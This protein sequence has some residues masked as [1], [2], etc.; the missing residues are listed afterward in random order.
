MLQNVFKMIGLWNV[1][2][3]NKKFGRK[4]VVQK[5]ICLITSECTG[6]DKYN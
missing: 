3:G 1:V 4:G 5:D 6:E 2:F